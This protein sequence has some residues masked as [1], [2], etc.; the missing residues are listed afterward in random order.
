MS[1]QTRKEILA[2]ISILLIILPYVF[3][4]V[5][6]FENSTDS[7][8][9]TNATSI[10]LARR[11][12]I[13][14]SQPYSFSF[15]LIPLGTLASLEACDMSIYLDSAN[16][17]ILIY[18]Y[19]QKTEN[20]PFTQYTRVNDIT[21]TAW[22]NIS[23][24]AFNLYSDS[25]F[26]LRVITTRRPGPANYEDW[27]VNET[28]WLQP[29]KYVD[30]DNQTL[31]NVAK[32]LASHLDTRTQKA[33]TILN[34]VAHHLTRD[35]SRL[36]DTW[37]ATLGEVHGNASYAYNVKT[38]VCRHFARLFVALCRA[39]N[40]PARI[41]LGYIVQGKTNIEAHAWS[42]FLDENK[43]WHV[44]EPYGAF[45]DQLPPSYF[46]LIHG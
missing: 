6:L 40:V 4:G 15:I 7:L 2:L 11:Y 23:L 3:L 16:S 26:F 35:R 14:I 5:S 19:S 18:R 45:Y 39:V 29:T 25:G 37:N 31:I 13:T 8:I 1:S 34:F 27:K 46:P 21:G 9:A 36:Y 28:L 44:I 41:V 20:A 24:S 12:G 32:N 22:L 38:G 17:S 33:Q 30:S 42:E 10:T 43:N